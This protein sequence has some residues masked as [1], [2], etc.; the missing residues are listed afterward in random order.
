MKLLLCLSILTLS[1]C[2][3][4][5]TYVSDR[6]GWF[7]T[8][9]GLFYCQKTGEG[10]EIIPMCTEAIVLDQANTYKRFLE[11]PVKKK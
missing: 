11:L 6:E 7:S 1:A 4:P 2:V 8:Q 5:T 3:S 9:R 10:S